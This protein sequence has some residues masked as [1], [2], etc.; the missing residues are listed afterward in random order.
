MWRNAGICAL[1]RPPHDV[2]R[3][4]TARGFCR[5]AN[6]DPP[7]ALFGICSGSRSGEG[8]E[9]PLFRMTMRFTALT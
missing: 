9:R 3:P 1:P 6:A 7:A 2:L 8:E 4:A 5:G